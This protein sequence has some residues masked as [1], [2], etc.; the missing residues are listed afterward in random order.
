MSK[1][2]KVQQKHIQKG[3]VCSHNRCPIALAIADTTDI[4][5][6]DREV[7]IGF[8]RIQLSRSAFRFIGRFDSEKPVKPFNFKLDI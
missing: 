5:V 2:I 8:T 1:L 7:R 6:S 4:A 3:V